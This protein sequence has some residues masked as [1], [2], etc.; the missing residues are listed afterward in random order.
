MIIENSMNNNTKFI[1]LIIL[2]DA[3]KS[4]W[5]ILPE[6]QKMALKSYIMNMIIK[7][8]SMENIDK[9]MESLLNKCNSILV[10]V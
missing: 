9:N 1:S 5:S 10:Q 7:M 8:G 4:R 6:E 2:E 3:I